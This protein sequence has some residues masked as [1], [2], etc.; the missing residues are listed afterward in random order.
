MITKALR[1]PACIATAASSGRNTNCPVAELAV[2]RPTTKPRRATGALA[3]SLN[4]LLPEAL[5]TGNLT[6]VPNA[7]VRQLTTDKKTG[8]VN[9]ADY[10]DRHSNEEFHVSAR[11]VVV[12][13]S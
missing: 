4:L 8:L 12:G 13:A 2:S 9:G 6:V 10:V 7:V 5:A 3:S 1:H 11:I